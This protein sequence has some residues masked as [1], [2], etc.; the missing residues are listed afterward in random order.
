MSVQEKKK[1]RDTKR[2]ARAIYQPGVSR[3]SRNKEEQS[4]GQIETKSPLD[5]ESGH[6]TTKQYS[7]HNK[8]QN[9]PPPVSAKSE[10]HEPILR[11]QQNTPTHQKSH[12]ADYSE[13]QF[14]PEK[15]RH[16]KGGNNVREPIQNVTSIEDNSR[17]NVTVV[18]QVFTPSNKH[19]R[20]GG[21]DTDVG[22]QIFSSQNDQRALKHDKI[23]ALMDIK[24]FGRGRGRDRSDRN[25]LTNPK[26]Q[27]PKS[28]ESNQQNPQDMTSAISQSDSKQ[29][30]RA[31]LDSGNESLTI[32][33]D[34][35]RSGTQRQVTT[36]KID[37]KNEATWQADKY[38]DIRRSPS[39]TVAA[40]PV[41]QDHQVISVPSENWPSE[42]KEK[43][44]KVVSENWQA[45]ESNDQTEAMYKSSDQP[46]LVAT[47][48]ASVVKIKSENISHVPEKH[49]EIDAVVEDHD[50]RGQRRRDDRR[51]NRKNGQRNQKPGKGRQ[52]RYQQTS[53]SQSHPQK[54]SQG[55][56]KL[57]ITVN[58]NV[59]EVRNVSNVSRSRSSSE[60]E[61]ERKPK[62]DRQ[63]VGRNPGENW[64]REPEHRSTEP[65]QMKPRGGGILKLP[66]DPGSFVGTPPKAQPQIVS[67]PGSSQ[68]NTHYPQAEP[69]PQRQR[70]HR[71]RS[72]RGDQSRLWDPS[73]P[74]E[75]PAIPPRQTQHEELQFYDPDE[76]NQYEYPSRTGSNQFEGHPNQYTAYKQQPVGHANWAD[77]VEA[78]YTEPP[79]EYYQRIP[80]SSQEYLQQTRALQTLHRD[81]AKRLLR[82]AERYCSDLRSVIDRRLTSEE[83]LAKA[84]E[85]RSDL[86]QQYE[87]V[88]LLDLNLCHENGVEQVLWKYAY[89]QVIEALRTELQDAD[90]EDVGLLKSWLLKLLDHG[91]SFYEGLITKLQSSYG[92]NLQHH[93]TCLDP[94]HSEK[95]RKIK[96]CLLSAQR[97]MIALGDLARY[98][99]HANDTTNFGKAR[100][101]YLKA[102]QLAPRN[103]RPYNQL[104]LLAL[105]T[106]RKLDAVYY[107]IRSLEAS[108]PFESARESLNTLFEEVRRKVAFTE[109]SKMEAYKK[110][111]ALKRQ[112]TKDHNNE[113]SARREVWISHD[114]HRVEEK[115]GDVEDEEEDEELAKLTPV[116]LNKRFVVSF[117]NVHGKLFTK[118][119]METFAMAVEGLLNEF[120]ALLNHSP[121]PINS[122]RLLQLMAINM[123]SVNHTGYKDPQD[124]YHYGRT[125]L[126]EQAIQVGLQMF[127]LLLH[128]S[129]LLL[130]E[131][132]DS[133]TFKDGNTLNEDLREL[134]PGVKVWADWMMSHVLLWEQ[135]LLNPNHYSATKDVWEEIANLLNTIITIDSSPTNFSLTKKEGWQ[136]V[137]LPEDAAMAGFVPLQ[138]IPLQPFYVPPGQDKIPSM[139][140]VRVNALVTWGNIMEGQECPLVAYS[141]AKKQYYSCAPSQNH[142][143]LQ[144]DKIE[145]EHLNM[146][147]EVI[148]EGEV[149]VEEVEGEDGNIRLLKEH[150]EQLQKKLEEQY[151]K[152]REIEA[153]V[154][155]HRTQRQ[156]VLEI[157]P[158]YLVPD[159]NCFIDHLQVI[160]C[161]VESKRYTLVVPLVVITELDGLSKG[162]REDQF[163][164]S[165]HA[166]MVQRSSTQAVEYLEDEFEKRNRHI[167]ALTAQGT[168]LQSISFRTEESSNKGNND[169]LILNCCLYYCSDKARD[170]MPKEKDAPICLRREVVL[171]TDDRNLR[172][173]ALNRNVP[174]KDIVSFSKWAK[175]K[176]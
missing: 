10:G 63:Y 13:K 20:S 49:Q 8:P 71:G 171:L 161:L 37:T 175:I 104:A 145:N 100:S 36:Q 111:V 155:S 70:D 23:P 9:R 102:Q 66:S 166:M 103:G 164:N 120:A 18:S 12:K 46:V 176:Q 123:F 39:C 41:I 44:V 47:S 3:L 31:H 122:T 92:F 50:N 86:E 30:N 112:R 90:P 162:G 95:T 5:K 85:T 119:G 109:Q 88:V 55:I 24:P 129:T 114:G 15:S 98:K 138:T 139:D 125:P 141:A 154:E 26:L 33:V 168:P 170:Y 117:L 48:P 151:R 61:P 22:S 68:Y 158:T 16:L 115:K 121:P 140:K 118:I 113:L 53:G 106:R 60:S 174:V 35:G 45:H 137:V 73:R 132:L 165:G 67:A 43:I 152:E 97:C 84:F 101:W 96:L 107:Y 128:S 131:H 173:K 57:S 28:Y 136:E 147:N 94:L 34:L 148:G 150:K 116:E 54:D 126:Q 156:L 169:D 142:P 52:D 110:K 27:S 153:I 25:K 38:S 62:K 14:V 1:K 51:G 89:H 87:G 64:N 2:P 130:N 157:S 143:L 149:F 167:R 108:N 77:Q 58:K 78:G 172:V 105:N 146:E 99:E 19:A 21:R 40:Q 72:K 79:Q 7:P 133:P 75:K 32:T 81:S 144:N 135:P 4:N 76:D 42:S 56:M 74:N 93:T 124:T 82:D 160:Q 65:D 134:L 69:R 59:R 83:R 163:A 17:S 159:T 80:P 11:T 6:P 91:T 29:M 127:A